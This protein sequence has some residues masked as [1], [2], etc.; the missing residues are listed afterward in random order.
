MPLW[1]TD[2]WKGQRIGTLLKAACLRG[3]E[4]NG[5][6]LRCLQG[7][8]Q[9]QQNDHF[10]MFE[11]AGIQV[12]EI[13]NVQLADAGVYTCTVMNSAGKA[14]VSTELTVQGKTK[15]MDEREHRCTRNV[16]KNS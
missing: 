15:E 5:V 7:E 12:L 4:S 11:K 3:C 13:Q 2:K 10:N 6:V 9:L 14:S 1:Q 16:L 8:I